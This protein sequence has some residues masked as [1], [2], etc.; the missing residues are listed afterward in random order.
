MMADSS[1]EV[2]KALW[3]RTWPA[4][5]EA[6]ARLV[7]F[8][9]AGVGA[10]LC[11]GWSESLPDNVELLA[12][13]LPGRENRMQEAPLREFDPLSKALH[14]ILPN[15]LDL[16]MGLFG[17]SFGGMIAFEVARGMVEYGAVPA[18]LFV[19]ACAAPQVHTVPDPISELPDEE[20][21]GQ[22]QANFGGIP[23][24]IAGQ[25][26]LLQLM[27]PALRADIHASETYRYTD[28]E[29]LPLPISA[30]GG[31]DDPMISMSDMAAWKE[32]TSERFRHRV[33]AGGHFFIRERFGQV[34][35]YVG[36]QLNDYVAAAMA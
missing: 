21:L 36:E 1:A 23:A 10:S 19:G 31:S 5:G 20:F 27:L 11:N 6:T 26:E 32:Q 15:Y 34:L 30:L 3:F 33:Y 16:P 17:Y 24:Q 35:R 7:C 28:G 14:K 2:S 4:R 22:I 12:V 9:H 13:Q 25:P 29:P 8:P 18:H